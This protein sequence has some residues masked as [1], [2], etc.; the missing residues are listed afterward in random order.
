MQLM[1]RREVVTGVR[2][3]TDFPAMNGG[4]RAPAVGVHALVMTYRLVQDVVVFIVLD[5]ILHPT[6]RQIKIH[7]YKRTTHYQ[8]FQIHAVTF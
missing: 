1:N 2:I 7:K 4:T 6:P 3:V 5:L 8:P